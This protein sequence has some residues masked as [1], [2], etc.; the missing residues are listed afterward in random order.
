VSS[1]LV[2]SG[3]ARPLFAVSPPGDSQRLFV[4]E[5]G[6]GDQASIRILDLVTG[7]IRSPAFLTLSGLQTAGERGLL[8][9]AF[10]PDFASNRRFFVN[11]TEPGQVPG[12]AAVSMIAELLVRADEPDQAD[13]ASLTTLLTF[14]Q[15]ASNHNGGWLGFGPDG[16]L[17]VATGDGGDA[18]D[19][20]PGHTPDI[21]NAQDVTDNLLGKILRLDVDGD[22]FPGDVERNYA[23]PADNPFV[24][25]AGDNEIWAYGLRNPWRPSF[26]RETGDLYLADVGQDRREEVSLE[27]AGSLGGENYGWRLREG[28]IATPTPAGSPVGGDP[29]PGALE[30]IY[31]YA[32]GNGPFEGASVTGGHVYRGPFADLRGLYFFADFTSDEIWSFRFDG[33]DPIDFDGGN[34]L[35]L[36]RRTDELAP[37]QGDIRDVSS[38]GEDG[39][40]H[41]YV[42]DRADGEVFRIVPEPMGATAVALAA[43]A[44]L[45]ARRGQV[46]SRRESSP[47]AVAP[48]TALSGTE[49]PATYAPASARGGSAS[50]R[51]R[52]ARI[53]RECWG[54]GCGT[55]LG[56]RVT[57][58]ERTSPRRPSMRVTASEARSASSSSLSST[59]SGQRSPPIMQASSS[60]PA[61][62]RPGKS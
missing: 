62:A 30:P 39:L 3:F 7:E 48:L 31:E 11:F 51:S 59:T 45:A 54:S 4:V 47:A 27:L 6:S 44:A 46:R 24:D 60:R 13:P 19:L 22:D 29:P 37:A 55:A 8:G 36:T 56:Q 23:I 2:A 14:S 16:Y 34:V 10:H 61:G 40:G 42:I 50:R 17:Y 21:G 58:R 32:H 35:E 1:E 12:E 9:L 15:P 26:D 5:Q 38:F 33:S 41:L 20:G 43:A 28:T 18:N 49:T 52:K 57:P 25:G 53:R